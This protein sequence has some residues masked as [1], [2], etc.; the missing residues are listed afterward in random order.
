MR[1]PRPL[2]M[3]AIA[4][5][6]PLAAAL[7]VSS[8]QSARQEEKQIRARYHQMR[9]ALS[10]EDT[11]VARAF[12]APDFRGTAHRN[13]DMLNRFAQ[14]LGLRSLIRFT[15]YRALICPE[16]LF[17]YRIIPGGH[18]IEMIKVDGAWF[19]TGEVNID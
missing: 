11:N 17:H 6:L 5:L 4:A 14:P 19:F 2:Y 10:S 7:I 1:S 9:V 3:L 8:Y 15:G 12:F 18:T 16:R 13:F